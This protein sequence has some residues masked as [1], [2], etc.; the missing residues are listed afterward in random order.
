[1]GMENTFPNDYRSLSQALLVGGWPTPL[2][3]ISQLGWLFPIYGK[4]Q[5][6]FQTTNQL[7][8]EHGFRWLCPAECQFC[9]LSWDVREA[10]VAS[11]KASRFLRWSNRMRRA[12]WMSDPGLV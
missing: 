3:N 6:V 2:K 10:T 8:Y 9:E 4:I 11:R 1:L 5:F 7:L 12:A